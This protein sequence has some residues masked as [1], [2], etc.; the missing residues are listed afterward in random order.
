MSKI[1]YNL[2][3]III[4]QLYNNLYKLRPNLNINY[5]K[6]LVLN[7]NYIVGIIYWYKAYIKAEM[8]Y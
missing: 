5:I 1:L 4:K 7:Y 2:N 8:L 6:Q 3:L